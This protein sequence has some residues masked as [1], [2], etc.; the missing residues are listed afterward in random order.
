MTD[1]A[2]ND[3]ARH[4]L[5]ILKLAVLDVL[6][7]QPLDYTGEHR[8]TVS[9]AKISKELGMQQLPSRFMRGMLD[10]LEDGDYADHVHDSGWRISNDGISVIERENS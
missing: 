9:A 4:A 7:Q 1:K 6:Y 2:R 3:F 8:M 10:V 5:E